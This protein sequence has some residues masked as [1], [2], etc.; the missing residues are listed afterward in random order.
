V[1]TVLLIRPVP[2]ILRCNPVPHPIHATVELMSD[3]QLGMECLTPHPHLQVSENTCHN[4]T[5][6]CQHFTLNSTSGCKILVT[7][8][9][10][11]F[12]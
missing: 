8:V 9:S 11:R 12:G 2:S 10:V 1:S 3:T 5:P 6:S 4:Y 7:L